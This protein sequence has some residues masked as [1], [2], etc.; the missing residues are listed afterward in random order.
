MLSIEDEK[1]ALLNKDKAL[2]LKNY[3]PLIRKITYEYAVKFR[4]FDRLELHNDLIQEA[5]ICFVNAVDKF[6]YECGCCFA[7]YV[8]KAIKYKSVSFINEKL[9]L[10][11]IPKN[12]SKSNPNKYPLKDSVFPTFGDKTEGYSL[13]CDYANKQLVNWLL[14]GLNDRERKI[15]ILRFGYDYNLPEIGEEYSISKQR[16]DQIIK[17]AMFK[18]KE[19]V[20]AV[21]E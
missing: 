15:L 17:R 20:E 9:R 14:G 4:K 19:Y 13:Q 1:A 6:D 11:R 21:S 12:E 8:S 7:T 18:I 10:V 5:S 16:V 3:K 2:L